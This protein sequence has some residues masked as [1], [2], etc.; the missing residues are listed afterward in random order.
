MTFEEYI[1]VT[2]ENVRLALKN[3]SPKELESGKVYSLLPLDGSVTGASIGRCLSATPHDY[4]YL[5]QVVFDSDFLEE[6]QKYG[7][8]MTVFFEDGPESI[9][10]LVRSVALTK[11]NVSELVEQELEERKKTSLQKVGAR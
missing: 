2:K 10:V 3:Y 7:V 11:V 8:D 9:D 1:D 4:E 6:V 5:A